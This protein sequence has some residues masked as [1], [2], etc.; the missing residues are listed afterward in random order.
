[1]SLKSVQILVLLLMY[2]PALVFGNAYAVVC[3]T[4]EGKLQIE[5]GAN[6]CNSS[7]AET[8]PSTSG[9][10]CGDCDDYNIKIGQTHR[11]TLDNPCDLLQIQTA[12]NSIVN[13]PPL[14]PVSIPV[15]LNTSTFD[16]IGSSIL[17]I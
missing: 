13:E 4:E 1:M 8:V 3:M 15:E 11:V 12:F 2:S 17:I 16:L 10:D 7:P 5:F 6:T 9:N 14:L